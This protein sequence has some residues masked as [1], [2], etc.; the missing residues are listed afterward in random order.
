LVASRASYPA[1]PAPIHSFH[2]TMHSSVMA[3]VQ[4]L[5]A[6]RACTV[7]NYNTRAAPMDSI[8]R[9]R[10]NDRLEPP[11]GRSRGWCRRSL[12]QDC[13]KDCAVR[14]GRR[15]GFRSCMHKR[16]RMDLPPEGPSKRLP[17]SPSE[18][19]GG[20]SSALNMP[21]PASLPTVH[22]PPSKAAAVNRQTL[23]VPGWCGEFSKRPARG[24]DRGH[25]SDPSH[26]GG[27]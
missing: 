2:S 26:C 15:H 19:V 9:S 24:Y 17:R 16:H 13:A 1:R 23:R 20:G 27:A 10:A 12:T 7:D 22:R 6:H 5:S 4:A 18:C 8:A 25:S 11:I 14:S 3:F 21:V